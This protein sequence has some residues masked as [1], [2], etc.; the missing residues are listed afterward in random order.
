[1]GLHSYRHVYLLECK[2]RL[3]FAIKILIEPGVWFMEGT[4]YFSSKIK[5]ML[6]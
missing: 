1:M 4:G 2:I 5:C 3:M 6:K